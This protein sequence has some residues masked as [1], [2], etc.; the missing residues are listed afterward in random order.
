[1]DGYFLS[2]PQNDVPRRGKTRLA[3]L[4]MEL[5]TQ[6]TKWGFIRAGVTSPN[7]LGYLFRQE[8]K[9]NQATP[10]ERQVARAAGLPRI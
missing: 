5:P 2:Y 6:T 1:M 8:Y 7:D 10:G 9:L 3:A 4:V